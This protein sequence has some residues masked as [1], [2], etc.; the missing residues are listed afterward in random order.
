MSCEYF[1]MDDG[2][3]YACTHSFTITPEPNWKLSKDGKVIKRFRGKPKLKSK[4]QAAQEEA[5]L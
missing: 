2:Y 4:E 1:E 3:G 5:E